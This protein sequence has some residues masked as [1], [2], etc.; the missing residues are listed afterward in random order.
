M[1]PIMDVSTDNLRDVL[2]R[3]AIDG[4][5]SRPVVAAVA[6]VT[7]AACAWR[8]TWHLLRHAVTV[9][10]EMGH[11]VAAWLF[12]R[13]ISGIKVHSDTSGLTITAGKP[14]GLGVLVTYMAGYPAPTLLGWG[15]VWAVLHGHAGAALGALTATL[16]LALLLSRNIYGLLVT[17]IAAAGSAWAFLAAPADTVATVTVAIALV[18]LLGAFRSTGDLWR[19]LSRGHGDGSDAAMAAAHSILPGRVWAALFAAVTGLG[20]VHT[21][22]T[23]WLGS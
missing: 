4:A 8:P 20:L 10:H 21:A 16:A 7:V 6:A 23:L 17:A 19:G 3:L 22:A 18:M 1:L 9:I 12:G 14:R 2:A 11:V 5:P 15:L 13:R